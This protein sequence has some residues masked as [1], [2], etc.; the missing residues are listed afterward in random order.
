MRISS[1]GSFVPVFWVVAEI[2]TY[3]VVIQT[4]GIAVAMLIGILSLGLGVFA[5]RRLGLSMAAVRQDDFATPE[6][7]WASFKRV[8]WAA[9][10]AF[11]LIMPG[12]LTNVIGAFLLIL[13]PQA[14]LMPK[15]AVQPGD[16][17]IID[18]DP[19]DWSAG[20]NDQGGQVKPPPPSGP[21]DTQRGNPG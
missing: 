1:F 20:T 8:G 13:N 2:I 19:S 16:S 5:F 9:L 14:W 18:L 10:G 4:F 11:L 21:P 17:D 12:F 7:L 15:R 6:A 3:G